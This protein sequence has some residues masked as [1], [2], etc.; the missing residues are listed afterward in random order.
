MNVE[1][2][3][4]KATASRFWLWLFVLFLLLVSCRQDERLKKLERPGQPKPAG[5]FVVPTFP[6][7]PHV[8]RSGDDH[9]AAR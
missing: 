3:I 6:H 4:N 9:L 5:G 8:P 2:E 7:T 1:D